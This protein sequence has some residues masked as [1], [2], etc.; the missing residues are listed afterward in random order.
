MLIENYIRTGWRNL[1]AHKLYSA[2]NILGL[3]IGLASCILITLFVRDELNYDTMW[4][5]SKDIY[6]TNTTFN[7]PG[8]DP[9][10][11]S[12]TPGIT[13]DALKDFY[14]EAE[15]IT[16][17]SAQSV[18][19][20]HNN[21][22]SS[23]VISLVDEDI[24]RIFQFNVIA[25]DIGTAL[26]DKNSIALSKTFAQKYL[27]EKY[28]IGETIS[29]S[30]QHFT[31]DYK[32][33]A[34]YKDIPDN[35]MVFAPAM[36]RIDPNDW[37]KKPWLF[38]DW[39]SVYSHIY[40]KFKEETN[41]STAF[42]SLDQ[43]VE[44]KYPALTQ[45]GPDIKKTDMIKMGMQNIEQLHLNPFGSGEFKPTGTMT[46][47]ITFSTISILILVIAGINFINLSTAK[48][49]QRAREV[50]MRKV[51]GASRGQLIAQFL[52]E[53]VILTL[54]SL[55]IGLAIV[56][57]SL[58]TINEI[59][60]KELTLD[61]SGIE[62]LRL[63]GISLFIGLVGG[64][65]PAFILSNFRPARV[66][67]AA[68]S[69]ASTTSS[70]L[71]SILVVIQF[72][73]S[74]GL[75]VSTGVVYGQMLYT[76]MMDPGFTKRNILVV[77]GMNLLGAI[78]RKD[79]ILN[80]FSQNRN[81]VISAT[82]SQDTPGR[83]IGNY[84]SIRTAEMA[85]ED[86]LIFGY[87]RVSYDFYK[88]YEVPIIAGRTFSKERNDHIEP[89]AQELRDGSTA[90][91]TVIVN[92]SAL[93]RLGIPSPEEAI[94][95]LL[96]TSAG[97]QNEQLDLGLEIIGV[98]PDIHL[99]GLKTNIRPEVYRITGYNGFLNA[100][101]V[102]FKGDPKKMLTFAENK[103]K[104]LVPSK[105]FNGQFVEDALGDLYQA[106]KGQAQMFAAFSLLA[107]IVACLGLYGLASFT[108]ERR[109]KEIGIRKVMGAT[110]LDIIKLL[111]W[112]FTK[113][114]LLANIIA[115]PIAFYIMSDWLEVF[116]YRIESPVII[117]LCVAGSIGAL[118]IAWGTVA[119][120]SIR[121]AKSNP[122]NALRYE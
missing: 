118:L 62:F 102:R 104:E 68:K 85:K 37:K 13:R 79:V 26:T 11:S 90:L 66:L 39:F 115:W 47:V 42:D 44:E 80:E 5:R 2:I 108:A 38:A 7:S 6:R 24:T 99:D 27:G 4:E 114:V 9:F 19:I 31:R 63:I 1:V 116:V 70:K 48:A 10:I 17:I 52:W 103:W 110:I 49:G 67:K 3:A 25:G 21:N 95:T 33:A 78:D 71:R 87:R 55:T 40:I 122:I 93:G 64:A 76:K 96:Y 16:R 74:I 46:T 28:P 119:S 35:S 53:S 58:G 34:I 111:L 101:S 45:G 92:V 82:L 61:Y 8:R 89:T 41:I 120:N 14:P 59:T 72:A 105:P 69:A 22:Y 100:L 121:V 94:G 73:V 60:G 112:Q 97:S 75:F 15:A 91:G 29:L 84:T 36:M 18:T 57:L 32:V 30:F 50:S 83:S 109:T 98:V 20:L 43:F 113:P 12:M 107:I 88:T 56:E 106:E 77:N 117:G 51:L 81:Q 65:Y 86:A 54:I 23:D